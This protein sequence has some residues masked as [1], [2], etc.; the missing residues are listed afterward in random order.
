IDN[1]L[2]WREVN[3]KEKG[4]VKDGNITIEARFTLSKIVGIRTHPFIDF[5]DSNDS[6]HDVALVING[7]KIY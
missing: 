1:L 5:W 2:A 4:F 3:N 6:C 7:E